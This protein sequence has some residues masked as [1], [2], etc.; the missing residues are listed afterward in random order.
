[1]DNDVPVARGLGLAVQRMGRSS[2]G[3]CCGGVQAVRVFRSLVDDHEV[4]LMIEGPWEDGV[5]FA[6][7]YAQLQTDR[8]ICP[9]RVIQLQHDL[10]QIT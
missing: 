10:H 8:S 7:Q 1:M 4:K 9:F 5:V 6:F 2:C 3:I